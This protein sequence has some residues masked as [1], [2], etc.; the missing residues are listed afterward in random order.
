[1]RV[2]RHVM[3]HGN[4]QSSQN[5]DAFRDQVHQFRLLV[6]VLIKEQMELVKGRACRLPMRFF[7]QVTKRHRIREQLVEPL[8]YF[9]PDRFLQIQ[10]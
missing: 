7:V 1:M 6:V 9:Q 8:G 2:V 4:A 10:R 3:C 5:L